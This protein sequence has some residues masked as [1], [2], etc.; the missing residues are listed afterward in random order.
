MLR[1][2]VLCLQGSGHLTGL[3]VG[4]ACAGELLRGDGGGLETRRLEDDEQ[5]QKCV[6]QAAA[7]VLAELYGI[8]SARVS[9]KT[10]RL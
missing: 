3:G 6:L 2:L 10:R 8:R 5:V 1:P 9:L 4:G 7:D